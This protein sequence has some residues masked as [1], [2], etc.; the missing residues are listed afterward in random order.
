MSKVMDFLKR[1]V[2]ETV[3]LKQKKA[4]AEFTEKEVKVVKEDV[5]KEIQT[6][7][8]NEYLRG[9]DLTP[10]FPP[11]EVPSL[12]QTIVPWVAIGVSALILIKVW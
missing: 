11:H 8:I 7:I 3:G 9:F 6:E 10:L 5:P 2:K 12:V 4:M 1:D